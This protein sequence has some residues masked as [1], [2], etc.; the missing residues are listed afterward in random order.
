MI[1]PWIHEGEEVL[2]MA[3]DSINTVCGYISANILWKD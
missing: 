2:S 3:V 1:G